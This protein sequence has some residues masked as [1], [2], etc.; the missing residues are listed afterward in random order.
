MRVQTEAPE[1]VLKAQPTGDVLR[2][3]R[4]V[5]PIDSIEKIT[6]AETAV[7]ESAR[8]LEISAR[9]HHRN[10]TR[11]AVLRQRAGL[12]AQPVPTVED[13]ATPNVPAGWFAGRVIRRERLT[14]DSNTLGKLK[15]ASGQVIDWKAGSFYVDTLE[16]LFNGVPVVVTG[17]FSGNGLYSIQEI[18]AAPPSYWPADELDGYDEVAAL[19]GA[20]ISRV[21]NAR[22]GLMAQHKS[23]CQD[24]TR[25]LSKPS[26]ASLIKVAT[27]YRLVCRPCK[28]QWIDAGRPV[29]AKA[30]VA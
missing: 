22:A 11:L 17:V 9:R 6:A 4:S 18:K 26:K 7:S 29:A 5:H 21:S 19:G 3:A 14:E 25:H 30:A 16:P 24:C 20:T 10:L 23:R 2:I 28:Q 8:C 27:G 13:L 15:L 12:D 1:I